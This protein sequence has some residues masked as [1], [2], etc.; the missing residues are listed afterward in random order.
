MRTPTPE[1]IRHMKDHIGDSK[2]PGLVVFI[3][4]SLTSAYVVVGLR[5][6]S[7]SIGKVKLGANDWLIVVALVNALFV[8]FAASSVDRTAG[9]R[10][11]LYCLLLH[12]G[13]TRCR[14]AH[15]LAHQSK[16][17]GHGM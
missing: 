13:A 2:V 5:F 8:M 4:I 14:K 7:R 10:D 1:Q 16:G 6:L 12:G 17:L 3:V 15:N 9:F 11:H